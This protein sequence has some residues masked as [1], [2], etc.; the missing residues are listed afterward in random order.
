MP[1]DTFFNLNE[2]KKEK[3]M[4]SA[5][6]EFMRNGFEKGN[7]GDIA[8]NAGVAKGSMYQYF[9]NKKE[10]FLYSVQ[11]ATELLLKLYYKS[12]DARDTSI[13]I[14]D[15]LYQNSKDTWSQARE[16]REIVIFI[17]DVWLGKYS[18][19]TDES[20]AYL[21]KISDEYT[22]KLIQ[23]GKA[24]GSIRKDIDDNILVLYLTGVSIKIKEYI[25]NRARALGEDLVDEDF[26]VNEKEVKA[27]I[28]LLK[29]GMGAR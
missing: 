7:I 3:V 15:Y 16:E 9:E 2:E 14:F 18:N 22:L 23:E 27:M 11:W 28:E 10:L 5:I 20:T 25:M 24:N 1:K 21:L 8:K 13:N 29:N 6:S 12:I 4:R 26:E 17:Q 19:L